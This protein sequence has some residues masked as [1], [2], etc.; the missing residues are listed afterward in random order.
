[1]LSGKI[2]YTMNA[3]S[4]TRAAEKENPD[5]SNKIWIS[6]ALKGPGR[7]IAPETLMNH[8]VIWE[9]A[10]NKEGAKQ[11]LVDLMDNYGEAFKASEFYHQPCFPSTVPN[12]KEQLSNDPRANPPD[13]YKV[14]ANALDWTTNIGYPGYA[15]AAIDEAVNTFVLPTIFAKVAREEMNAED[16]ARAVE[17]E[18]RRIFDKWK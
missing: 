4:I 2:S 6:S 13:K 16:G 8:Y 14:L 18:I 3:I 9:F 1:M 5:M 10:E 12:L 17:K 7:R 15:T 11:F